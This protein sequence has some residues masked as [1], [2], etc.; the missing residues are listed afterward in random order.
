MPVYPGAICPFG[1][2]AKAKKIPAIQTLAF[3]AT[4]AQASG[5]P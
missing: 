3:K 4:A 2:A 1:R 5:L